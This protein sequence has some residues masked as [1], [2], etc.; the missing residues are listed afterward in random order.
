MSIAANFPLEAS[1]IVLIAGTGSSSRLLLPNGE[2]LCCGGWGHLI[3]DYG[4]GYWIAA[5]YVKSQFL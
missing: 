3:G 5:R 2:V 4:S 1:A